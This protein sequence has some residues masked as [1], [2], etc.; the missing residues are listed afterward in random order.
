MLFVRIT[1]YK[2]KPLLMCMVIFKDK[3]GITDLRVP[4]YLSEKQD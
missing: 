4:L 3:L 1:K 2:V